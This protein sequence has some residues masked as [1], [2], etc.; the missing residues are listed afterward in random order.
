MGATPGTLTDSLCVG[1]SS[2][3]WPV[4]PQ[5]IGLSTLPLHSARPVLRVGLWAIPGCVQGSLLAL[6]LGVTPGGVQGTLWGARDQTGAATYK[7]SALPTVLSLHT[8]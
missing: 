3:E 6:H 5:L 4:Y 8:N 2:P 7:A 1:T